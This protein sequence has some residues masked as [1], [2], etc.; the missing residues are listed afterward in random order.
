M[1]KKGTL[2][3]IATPIG[4]LEDITHRAIRVLN[5]VDVICSEDTRQT[6]KLLNRYQIPTSQISYRD[7]NHTRVVGEI[8]QRLDAGQDVAL[9]SDSG[10]PLISDPGF[11][12]V[13]DVL[14]HDF[15]IIPIPGPSAITAAIS[16]AG[17]PTDRFTFLGF[18]PKKDNARKDLLTKYGSLDSTL[19]IYESPFRLKKLLEEIK[20]TLGNRFIGICAELT[21][22]HEN[23][24]RGLIDNV[25]L[26]E[27]V[28]K[29]EYV[30][31][32]AKEGYSGGK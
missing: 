8:I 30:V 22:V 20:E 5:E 9:V 26:D 31:L 13:E 3:I 24:S 28:E 12:L 29:G 27:I 23:I 11:K 21:K 14:S 10:T 16:A 18:L 4:N 19:I 25:S 15:R 32:I 17:L 1:F 2:F 6:K 7:Q